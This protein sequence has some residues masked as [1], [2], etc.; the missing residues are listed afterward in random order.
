LVVT[1]R[2]TLV[3]VCVNVTV[4]FG[5]AD[6]VWSVTVPTAVVVLS[7]AFANTDS[8]PPSNSAAIL[9]IDLIET[10]PI[11]PF[12]YLAAIARPYSIPVFKISASSETELWEQA[13]LSSQ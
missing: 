7:C 3:S 2:F 10:L 8:N 11:G 5:T 4:A 6:P 1:T 9:V 13:W 12:V